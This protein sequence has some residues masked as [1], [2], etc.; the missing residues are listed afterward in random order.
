MSEY[1]RVQ[2][3]TMSASP[4]ND[5]FKHAHKTKL[6]YIYPTSDIDMVLIELFPNPHVVAFLEYKYGE[7]DTT[8]TQKVLL[9]S[10]MK[11]APVF[12]VR[13]DDP[14]NGPFTITRWPVGETV[15]LKDWTHFEEWE[16]KLRAQL[17]G[18]HSG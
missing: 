18:G 16:K 5:L 8:K 4:M 3:L 11:I 10:L 2:K 9:S 15:L 14:E 17:K 12:I 7:D 6:P 1:T 13:S